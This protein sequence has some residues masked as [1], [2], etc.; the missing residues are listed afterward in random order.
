MPRLDVIG[1]D[2]TGKY[3]LV[4]VGR[5]R[6]APRSVR[7]LPTPE[8]LEPLAAS[9]KRHG[10]LQPIVVRPAGPD[11]E[12]VCGIRRWLAAREARLGTIPAIVRD[13]DDREAVEMALAENRD[14]KPLSDEEQ[15]RALAHLTVLFPVRSRQELLAWVRPPEAAEERPEEPV[16]PSWMDES[17][18]TPV[19][20]PPHAGERTVVPGEVPKY[21]LEQAAERAG[22]EPETPAPRGP[23]RLLPQVRDFLELFTKTGMMDSVQTQALVDGLI[24]AMEQGPPHGFLNLAYREPPRKYLP[25]HCLNVAKL[26]L[27]LGRAQGLERA[28]LAALSLSALL[29][30]VGMFQ[31]DEHAF[32]R[33]TALS[34]TEWEEVRSHP[35]EG[36]IL[37]TKEALLRE[38]FAHLSVPA[39]SPD[40]EK[41]K[42]QIHVFAKIVNVVDTY[43][44]MVSPRVHRLPV[45]PHEGMR[46]L[47]D[48]GAKGMLDWTLVELFARTMGLHPIAS[49]VRMQTG[50]V[51]IVVRANPESPALPVVRVIADSTGRILVRPVLLDLA[52]QDPPLVFDPIARPV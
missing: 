24:E 13:L 29:H 18:E 37:L 28:D 2:R 44:S 22:A 32:K 26:A 45:L 7:T 27:F 33:R 38:V 9:V 50:E 48:E 31:V 11:F 20:E 46:A 5:I 3:K 49:Y 19:A 47:M 15:R 14:H 6:L 42:E 43:E 30:D 10:I 21:W 17:A 40:E 8:E 25:R 34:D 39:S 4:P 35:R 51:G 16:L 1:V 52:L 23:R 41:R 12:V 36:Q